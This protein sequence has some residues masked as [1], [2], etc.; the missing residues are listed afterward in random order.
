MHIVTVCQY[1]LVR[2]KTYYQDLVTQAQG[3]AA[4]PGNLLITRGTSRYLQANTPVC[5]CILNCKREVTVRCRRMADLD[6]RLSR[7]LIGDHMQAF[8]YEL[9]KPQQ[10]TLSA[11]LSTKGANTFASVSAD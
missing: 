8:V 5:R 10:C 7:Q 3:Q 4:Y 2:A 6:L 9:L 11:R 1:M